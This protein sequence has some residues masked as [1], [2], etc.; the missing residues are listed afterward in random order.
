MES[1][2][3]FLEHH[4]SSGFKSFFSFLGFPVSSGKFLVTHFFIFGFEK[5]TMV[6]NG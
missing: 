3:S 1:I 4:P 6:A 5:V 2:F